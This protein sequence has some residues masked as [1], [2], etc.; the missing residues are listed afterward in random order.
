MPLKGKE[1]SDS[2]N[3]EVEGSNA[4]CDKV[5]VKV[6]SFWTNNA[7]LFFIQLDASFRLAGV[8]VEQTKFDYLVAALDPETLSHATDIV[9]EPPPHPYTALK[10]R[11]LTQFEVSQTKKLKNLIKDLELG[12]RSPSMLLRQMRDL[13]ERQYL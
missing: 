2:G 11:L 5:G 10:S 6:P 7:K 4:G 12:D 9:C 1:G 8:T 13:S 3:K